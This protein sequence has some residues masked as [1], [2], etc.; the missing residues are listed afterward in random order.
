MKS[1][2]VVATILLLALAIGPGTASL[3]GH[4]P[5]QPP[6][7]QPPPTFRSGVDVV[8]MDVRVV[9]GRGKPVTD[10]KADD[11]EVLESG[12]VR[13]IVVF[14]HV[15][16]PSGSYVEVARRTIGAEVSTNRGAPRGHL[17]IIAF[18]QSHIT[19]GNEQ[20]A[21]QA[22][23][24][25]IRNRVRP[26]DRV[27]LFALGGPGPR[28]P[29]TADT[30]AVLSRLIEVRGM[31]DK[32]AFGTM[33]GMTV[34]EA[35]EITRGN[36]T[37]LQRVV[38]RANS[39]DPSV[40]LA[41]AVQNARAGGL[42]DA[43]PY[44]LL[45]SV[46]K[47]NAKSVVDRA[48]GETRAF[49]ADFATVIRSVAGFEGRKSVILISEGFFSDYVRAEV[50]RVAAAAAQA[51]AAIYSLDVNRRGTDLN[52]ATPAGN[53]PSVEIQDRVEPLGSLAAETSGE[54]VLDASSRMDAT[55]ERIAD[56]SLDYYVVGFE[57]AGGSQGTDSDRYHRVTIRAKKGGLS[58]RTRTGYAFRDAATGK[59]RRRNI[60]MALAAPFPQQGVPVDV[61]T[62]VS[63]G[64]SPGAH[65]VVLSV[66]AELPVE[67]GGS[68]KPADVVFV[69][70]STRDGR[71]VASGTDVMTLPTAPARGGAGIGRYHVQFEAPPGEYLMRVVVREPDDGV[72][73]SVD[74]RFDVRYFDGTDVTASD[75]FVGR[76]GRDALPVRA[77]AYS[78]DG[79]TAAIEIYARNAGDLETAGVDAALLDADGAAVVRTKA[80]LQEVKHAPSSISS[81]VAVIDLPLASLP[82]GDYALRATLKSKGETVQTFEREVEVLQGSAPPVTEPQ[83]APPRA[84]NPTDILNGALTQR[85]ISRLLNEVTDPATRKAALLAN[86]QTWDS[87]AAAVPVAA[88]STKQGLVLRGLGRFARRQYTDA[89]ADFQAALALDADE[90][91]TAFLLGWARSAGGDKAGAITAWRAATVAAPALIP[92]YL[93]LADAYMEQAQRDLALQV[94]RAGL[95]ANPKSLELQGKLAELERR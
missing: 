53:D 24:R 36:D 31:L 10:L 68:R 34:F 76:G 55:F 5:A 12:Q 27:G 59:D 50:D 2:S 93:A 69:A 89:S 18:D 28:V 32:E 83:Q 49:L 41:A 47:T 62:Y 71:V 35:Y 30:R 42:P 63:R 84:F 75:L 48:D 91:V 25:F 74:R 33:G 19:P 80:T 92:A 43:T 86:A 81:R 94:V 39:S 70:R 72:T 44:S 57:P 85:F 23:D 17:Y 67:S 22:A 26:G 87:L 38:A 6:A 29:F 37:V 13:P 79:L 4:A 3:S 15:A 16:E 51:Y 82:A 78:G 9:D 90:E 40:D 65:R 11:L 54:L 1:S 21:R 14:Q 52:Q 60:D 61:T 45:Q 88:L 58:V 95:A 77:R 7:A 20:R 64:T 66:E 56:E 46:L 8:R 73:G